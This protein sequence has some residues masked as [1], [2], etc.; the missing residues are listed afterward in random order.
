[1][2]FPACCLPCPPPS[3]K[4]EGSLVVSCQLRDNQDPTPHPHQTQRITRRGSTESHSRQGLCWFLAWTLAFIFWVMLSWH[5]G[6][7]IS[8]KVY[9]QYYL[10]LSLAI[11]WRIR[12]IVVVV[13]AQA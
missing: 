1:M 6:S 7:R 4:A 10:C 11:L 2:V 13:L 9:F 8:N 5:L 3:L 12:Y